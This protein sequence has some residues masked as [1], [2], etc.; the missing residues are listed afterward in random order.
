M[1]TQ[2]SSR[3]NGGARPPRDHGNLTVYG[4]KPVLEALQDPG[5]TVIRLHLARSN[6]P[7]DLLNTIVEL[8]QQAGV[9]ISHHGKMELSRISRNSRQDQGMAADLRCKR[10]LELQ[11][12]TTNRENLR[13]IA[14]DH[15]NNP[16]NLGMAI[17]SIAAGYVDGLLLAREPGN[18]SL[19]PLVIKA[20][21]GVFFRTPVYRCDQ[22][23]NALETLQHCGYQVVTLEASAEQSLYQLPI[24][25][26]CIFVLGNETEGLSTAVA[27]L[28]NYRAAI[29]LR[30]GVESLNVAV[31]ASLIAFLPQLLGTTQQEARKAP[32]KSA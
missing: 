10:L 31:T 17:R 20:S 23:A 3:K 27:S 9:P 6:Q 29:P 30:R 26:R 11:D 18:T 24:P 28:T 21:A 14:I 2:S 5:V 32:D 16:Q 13:L 8:A 1:T 7:S 15:I 22:L 12:L 25:E 4:R 19:S